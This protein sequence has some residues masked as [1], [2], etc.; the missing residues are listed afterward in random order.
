VKPVR[1]HAVCTIRAP[2]DAVYD[3]ITGAESVP[4]HFPSAAKAVRILG[5]FLI[6][7]VSLAYWKR[8][9]IGKMKKRLDS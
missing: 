1:L 9:V 8:A 2:R 6:R 4:R 3:L 7:T 5:G